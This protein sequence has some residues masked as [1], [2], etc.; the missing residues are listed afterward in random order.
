MK[1]FG[2]LLAAIALALIQACLGQDV[3]QDVDN[4]TLESVSATLSRLNWTGPRSADC[5]AV[6]T[7]SVFRGT[8]EDF[9][10]SVRN[11][12]ATGLSRMTYLAK[13]PPPARDYYYFVKADVTPASCALHS[14]AI[15][16]YPLDLGQSFSVTVGGDSGTC[17]AHSTSELSCPGPLPDFHSVIANQAG[18][19]YLIGCRSEDYETG[20]W[21]CVNLTPGMYRIEIHSQTL[22]V[23]DSGMVKINVSTGKKIAPITPVFSILARMK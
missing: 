8:S 21:S 9:T 14:G 3:G 1:K 7:Y 5:V 18:H 12:I 22:T 17:T 2:L 20:A 10:P 16:V 13:E 6:V 19:D 11:R 15:S 4:L 23:W